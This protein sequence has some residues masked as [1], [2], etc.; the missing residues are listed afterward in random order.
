MEKWVNVPTQ[1]ASR[2]QWMPGE[3]GKIPIKSSTA[4][5]AEAKTS[6]KALK[7]QKC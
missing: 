3:Q 6:I 4:F 5:L 1:W 7:K 2:Y